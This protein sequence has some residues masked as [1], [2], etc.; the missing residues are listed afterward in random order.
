[1]CLLDRG[2]RFAKANKIEGL[3]SGDV[4]IFCA[5]VDGEFKG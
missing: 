4:A 1:M 2:L 5:N 3:T